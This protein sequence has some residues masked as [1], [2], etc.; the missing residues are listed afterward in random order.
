MT[1]FK[2]TVPTLSVKSSF[3]NDPSSA[4]TAYGD[5]YGVRGAKPRYMRVGNNFF[6]IFAV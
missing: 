1:F 4:P 2:K 3:S 5:I 6:C